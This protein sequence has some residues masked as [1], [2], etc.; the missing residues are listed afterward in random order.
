MYQI[1]LYSLYDSIIFTLWSYSYHL[2][3][4]VTLSSTFQKASLFVTRLILLHA[5]GLKM[6]WDDQF[7]S[8]LYSTKT[9]YL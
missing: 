4:I 1:C 7:V 6:Y 8:R 2:H 9:I 5:I 3:N